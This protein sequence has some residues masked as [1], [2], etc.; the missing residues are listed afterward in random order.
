MRKT[1]NLILSFDSLDPE[2]K[3][4][5]AKELIPYRVPL[6]KC[7]AALYTARAYSEIGDDTE[8]D[9][10]IQL[11]LSYAPAEEMKEYLSTYANREWGNGEERWLGVTGGGS[12]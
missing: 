4:R 7:T 5:N 10:Y 1:V 6:L 3:L 8:H 9:E 12:D 11:A 2:T